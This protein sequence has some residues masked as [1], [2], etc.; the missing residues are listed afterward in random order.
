MHSSSELTSS[1]DNT[2]PFAMFTLLLLRFPG[3]ASFF[4][5]AFFIFRVETNEKKIK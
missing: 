2:I 3:P 1:T 4:V 5:A